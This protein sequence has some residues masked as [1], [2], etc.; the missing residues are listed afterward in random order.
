MLI[1]QEEV[2]RRLKE[3][4]TGCLHI[5]A[6]ECE[7]MSFYERLGMSPD[8]VVWIDAIPSGFDVIVQKDFPRNNIVRELVNKDEH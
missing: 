5:G 7:E 3:P 1:S 4:M 2:I 8:D 6:H